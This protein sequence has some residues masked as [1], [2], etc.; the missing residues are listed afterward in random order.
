MLTSMTAV[1]FISEIQLST[2]DTSVKLGDLGDVA[3]CLQKLDYMRFFV[4]WGVRVSDCPYTLGIRPIFEG[5]KGDRR[6]TISLRGLISIM[7]RKL[8][9]VRRLQTFRFSREFN[10]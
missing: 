4:F 1:R 9:L 8:L 10:A 6:V 3:G 2:R 7:R 5:D